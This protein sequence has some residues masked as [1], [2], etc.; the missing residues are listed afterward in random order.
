MLYLLFWFVFKPLVTP[1]DSGLNH[2]MIKR[3]SLWWW[4][5]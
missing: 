3:F 4:V 1:G 2:Q 5:D